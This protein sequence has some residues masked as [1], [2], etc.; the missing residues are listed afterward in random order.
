M[1]I[2]K[3]ADISVTSNMAY[4][5]HNT[6]ECLRVPVYHN[7]AYAAVNLGEK[8]ESVEVMVP[9]KAYALHNVPG[10]NMKFPVYPNEVYAMCNKNHGQPVNMLKK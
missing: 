10:Y 3:K 6:S 4:S 5:Y 7:Q 9:N 8:H 1:G 2:K